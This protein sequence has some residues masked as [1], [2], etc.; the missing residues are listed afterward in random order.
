MVDGLP[1]NRLSELRRSSII[2]TFGPGAIVDATPK[3]GGGGG[4][5]RDVERFY[6]VSAMIFRFSR[7]YAANCGG[8]V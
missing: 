8:G 3:I 2:G 4:V 1:K 5:V 7:P 6:T